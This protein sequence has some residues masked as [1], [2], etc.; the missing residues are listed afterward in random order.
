MASIKI[1]SLNVGMPKQIRFNQ[2]DVST[3]IIKSATD[4]YLYLSI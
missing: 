3:G 2:K 1:L 4:E